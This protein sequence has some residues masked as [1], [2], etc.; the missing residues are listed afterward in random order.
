MSSSWR[1]GP[2]ERSEAS[3][4][5]GGNSKDDKLAKERREEVDRGRNGPMEGGGK[6]TCSPQTKKIVYKD[7]W[8]LLEFEI[9]YAEGQIRIKTL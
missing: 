5:K 7:D 8:G 3:G 6:K 2:R 9:V 1:E 4:H